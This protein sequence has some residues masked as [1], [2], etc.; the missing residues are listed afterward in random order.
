MIDEN[1]KW[2][3]Y[4]EEKEFTPEQKLEKER[5][6]K[7]I[8]E[9]LNILERVFDAVQ[10][11]GCSNERGETSWNSGGFGNYFSRYGL[12]KSFVVRSEQAM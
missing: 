1:E 8:K 12:A 10:I 6:D 2:K 5:Q 7:A 11:L 3:E 9:A 4:R